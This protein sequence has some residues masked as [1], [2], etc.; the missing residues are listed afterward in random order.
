MRAARLSLA[1][2]VALTA[3]CGKKQPQ[4]IQIGATL[5]LT[6]DVA[7]YGVSAQHG[8]EILVQ[9]VNDSGGIDGR[10][11]EVVF[12]DDEGKASEAVNI[13]N[14]FVNVL[15]VPAVIGSAGSSVTL[16]IAP[17]ANKTKTLLISP[18]SS[19]KKLTKEGG[20]YFFR[21]C[22]A[23]DQQA[24]ILADWVFD[25]GFKKVVVVYTNND[26]GASLA[27]DFKE[28]FEGE[29]GK[30]VLSEA[31][32][33]AQQDFRAVISKIKRVKFDALVSPTYPKEGGALL[34]QAKELGLKAPFFGGD[35]WGAP[36]FLTIAGTAANGAKFTAPSAYKGKEYE[37]FAAAYNK[38]FNSEPTVFSAYGYD[39]AKAVALAIRECGDNISGE[40]IKNKI[41]AIKFQGV[42]N[43][44]EFDQNGDL[45][46]QAFTK[47]LIKDG[48]VQVL[49]SQS[50][51]F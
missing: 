27:N 6:G 14:N 2:L 42:S 43:F 36:E 3:G 1:L 35:N 22:P 24:R 4:V 19:S 5:P 47:N 13:M 39:A 18:I 16:A 49:A 9:Q 41:A 11:F 12:Q 25:E 33:E 32:A 26:W 23:D 29:G 40:N 31:T 38:Q 21:V 28:K 7:S 37:L 46:T 15:K 45:K 20:E 50:E 8:M 10:R 34:K 48:K 17:I 44:I 30:V 51:Q